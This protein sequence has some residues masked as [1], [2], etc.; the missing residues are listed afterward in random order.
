MHAIL[1]LRRSINN[2]DSYGMEKTWLC[3]IL[4]ADG[5]KCQNPASRAF[6]GNPL[7]CYPGF[8][9]PTRNSEI[10]AGTEETA[11]IA[12]PAACPEPMRGPVEGLETMSA[13]Y[14]KEFLWKRA[15][16]GMGKS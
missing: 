9:A 13:G 5:E 15:V 10:E 4:S 1:W 11:M 6:F 16:Y 14:P 2:S 8:V 7:P 3:H 12:C